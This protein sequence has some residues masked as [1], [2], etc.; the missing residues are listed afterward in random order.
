MTYEEL[1]Y[2][3]SWSLNQKIDHALGVIE[4]FYNRLDGDVYVSFSGGRDSTVLLW[5]V[6]L[7]YPNVKAVFCN[8]RNEYPDI[9]KFVR[10]IDNVE[11]IYPEMKPKDVFAKHGFPLI[12]KEISQYIRSV[13]KNPSGLQSRRAMGL[14]TPEEKAKYKFKGEIPR[15]YWR[16]INL[17]NISDRCCYELKK[18]PF[19]IYDKE[20]GLHPMLGIMADE[21]SQ[22]ANSYINRGGCNSFN[23]KRINS[24]PMSIWIGDDV[25]FCIDKYKIPISPIYPKG[26]KRTGCMFC[27]FGCQFQEDNRLQLVYDLYPKSYSMFMDYLNDGITYREAL[28]TVLAINGLSLPDENKQL[29]ILFQ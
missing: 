6:R 19:K 9:V 12:S 23:S 18:K 27:G 8:T 7:I 14:L 11:I 17:F 21:S 15:K 10:G 22:R 26:A 24:H 20:T 2:R 13:Q 4:Q 1:K 5:L 25:S 3:Q 16:L 29:K 28:R